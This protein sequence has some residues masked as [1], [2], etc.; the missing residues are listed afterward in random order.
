MADALGFPRRHVH[1]QQRALRQAAL[2]DEGHE[3]GREGR[4]VAEVD[5]GLGREREGHRRQPEERALAGSAHRSRIEDVVAEVRATVDARKHQVGPARQQLDD[6]QVDAVGGGAVDGVD[7]LLDPLRPQRVLEGERLRAGRHLA[8]GSHHVH[9]AQRSQGRR[10]RLDAR[11]VYPVVVGDE[12]ERLG[13]WAEEWPRSE[14]PR[15]RYAK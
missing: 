1:V 3:P 12:Q 2:E 11:G 5:L 14:R 10:Q 7:A 13:A 6:G 15:P 8:V 9:L 4:G